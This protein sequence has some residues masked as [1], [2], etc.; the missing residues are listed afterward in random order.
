MPNCI[1][2]NWLKSMM[3]FWNFSSWWTTWQ[4]FFHVSYA[5]IQCIFWSFDKI[6]ELL[7]L[8][9]IRRLVMISEIVKFRK[10]L[11]IVYIFENWEYL[12][13]WKLWLF[14]ESMVKII[15]QFWI[16][17][18]CENVHR[19]TQIRCHMNFSYVS[20]LLLFSVVE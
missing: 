19:T 13:L 1:I 9:S 2:Q 20:V 16:T 17:K 8:E 7:W 12:Q 6:W 4:S 14:G 18:H 11:Q 5:C 3:I 10:I 15:K